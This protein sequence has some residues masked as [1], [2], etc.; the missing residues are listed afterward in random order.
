MRV[1]SKLIQF[2]LLQFTIWQPQIAS[3]L[4]LERM[5]EFPQKDGTTII[6]TLS[7]D[8]NED[9]FINTN[10]N[11]LEVNAEGKVI[12]I[13][14]TTSNVSKWKASL[15]TTKF[16]LQAGEVKRV[17]LTSLEPLR[18]LEHDEGYIVRFS[19]E[20]VSSI[21]N[22]LSVNYGYGVLSIFESPNTKG[23]P[24]VGRNNKGVMINNKSNKLLN[25]RLCDPYE[26]DYECESRGYLLPDR[27]KNFTLN[28]N[29]VGRPIKI[30]I[31]SND[32]SVKYEEI[33]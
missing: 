5:V 8:T 33:I 24:K 14:Y 10:I 22:E 1:S 23:A 12:E 3:A 4:S 6:Y 15:S 13:P 30:L 9:L 29:L 19:P 11:E 20:K 27:K 31:N 25:V 7:N 16:I 21:N 2:A 18:V 26:K 32:G 28:D 17:T